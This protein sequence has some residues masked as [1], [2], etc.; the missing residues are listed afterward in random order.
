MIE[1]SLIE[2]LLAIPDVKALFKG[3]IYYRVSPA[4]VK[5]PWCIISNA[6]GSRVHL[7]QSGLTEAFDTILIYVDTADQFAG[8]AMAERLIGA[9]ENYRGAMGTESDLVINCESIRDLNGWQGNYRFILPI[10]VRYIIPTNV[11]H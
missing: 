7:T 2:Y 10:H 4:T 11:P 8:R 1:K 3:Q 9:L 6:G 5:L